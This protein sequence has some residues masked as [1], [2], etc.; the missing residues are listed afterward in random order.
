[1]SDKEADYAELPELVNNDTVSLDEAVIEQRDSASDVSAEVEAITHE[2]NAS[3]INHE[4][5]V[6]PDG[7]RYNRDEIL[8]DFSKPGLHDVNEVVIK[9][10]GDDAP[11]ANALHSDAGSAG[12]ENTVEPAID[13][14]LDSSADLASDESVASDDLDANSNPDGYREY[15]HITT[16][17]DSQEPE[18]IYARPYQKGETLSESIAIS[19]A[20]FN[21]G[22][23]VAGDFIAHAKDEAEHQWLITRAEL[24]ANYRATSGDDRDAQNQASDSLVADE[25]ELSTLK[26]EGMS[27]SEPSPI[28]SMVI[29]GFSKK[30][31]APKAEQAPVQ[32]N[33]PTLGYASFIQRQHDAAQHY[34]S[35]NEESIRASGK[36][37]KAL[38]SLKHALITLEQTPNWDGS[39]TFDGVLKL[40][41]QLI[42]TSKNGQ[43][44]KMLDH[45]AKTDHPEAN[46]A[47]S[48]FMKDMLNYTRDTSPVNESVTQRQLSAVVGQVKHASLLDE[49]SRV[50]IATEFGLAGGRQLEPVVNAAKSATSGFLPVI[51]RIEPELKDKKPTKEVPMAQQTATNEMDLMTRLYEDGGFA[52]RFKHCF[53][54]QDVVKHETL[55]SGFVIEHINPDKKQEKPFNHKLK[56]A[57]ETDSESGRSGLSVTS[58]FPNE[59]LKGNEE[60]LIQDY[61]KMFKAMYESGLDEFVCSSDDNKQLA[62]ATAAFEAFAAGVK[63]N[64]SLK[65]EI[66]NGVRKTVIWPKEPASDNP[67]ATSPSPLAEAAQKAVSQPKSDESAVSDKKADGLYLAADNTTNELKE[68]DSNNPDNTSPTR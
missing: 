38:G 8:A 2:S 41:G 17:S 63:D 5:P 52:A 13:E 16:D 40:N 59:E 24:L 19:E 61:Q 31:L 47:L 23:P 42:P 10:T 12:H 30:P 54:K 37:K 1:M 36:L 64:A 25:G 26:V 32:P 62:L 67:Q 43:L 15:Q 22:S 21:A 65:L 39:I 60:K 7:I 53:M 27:R 45:G 56:Y 46:A 48:E 57:N 3:A 55:D 6:Q 11:T 66:G 14:G 58:T 20:D 49:Q 9:P 18:I 35:Q 28:A 33:L 34:I 50:L 51:Q 4:P 44:F 68:D 29:Q